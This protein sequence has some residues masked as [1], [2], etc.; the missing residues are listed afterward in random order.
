MS[1]SKILHFKRKL[2]LASPFRLDERCPIFRW[3]TLLNYLYTDK[4]DFLPL[5]SATAE[6]Q[7]RESESSANYPDKPRCSA[8]S[9]YRLACKVSMFRHTELHGVSL[10]DAL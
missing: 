5:G 7:P 1:S 2:A 10:N 3:Y 8:K 9:M 4:V 6:G